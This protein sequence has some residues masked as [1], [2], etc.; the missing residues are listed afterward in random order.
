MQGRASD[1]TQVP[2]VYTWGLNCSG[3]LGRFAGEYDAQRGA[4]DI[5]GFMAL[6]TGAGVETTNSEIFMYPKIAIHRQDGPK[7]F[8]GSLGPIEK[9]AGECVAMAC[10]SKHTL[11]LTDL[12]EI[13]AF[14][15][16]EHGVLG[17]GD[18]ASWPVPKLI[19]FLANPGFLV[20]QARARRCLPLCEN[21]IAVVLVSMHRHV[22]W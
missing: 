9:T 19:D 5:K 8:L 21:L 1:R 22:S 16:G 10:G 13:F 6:Q 7:D 14:G 12:G 3:Q 15:A 17:Q 2:Q 4:I 18:E 20:E 11:V